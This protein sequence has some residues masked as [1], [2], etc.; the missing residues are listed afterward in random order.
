MTNIGQ[1][2]GK[3]AIGGLI[4]FASSDGNESYISISTSKSVITGTSY[5]GCIAGY[6]SNVSVNN[7]SNEGSE[8]ITVDASIDTNGNKISYVGGYV[9]RG[10]Y[11]S[12]CD[13]NVEIYAV[14]SYVGG[15]AGWSN[16]N[17]SNCNNTGKITSQGDYIGGIIGYL[18]NST[19]VES[20][21]N[22]GDI[23]GNNYVGGII[24]NFN[25]NISTNSNYDVYLTSL[26]N[27]GEIIGNDYVGG[28]SG[29]IYANNS[30][31]GN[32]STFKIER[33]TNAGIIVVLLE[34]SMYGGYFGYGYSDGSASY[35]VY[36]SNL[37]EGL[38]N[39]GQ[40]VNITERS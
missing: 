31:S 11:I 7:C 16:G 17:I 5:V 4:G 19:K 21:S 3:E 14:G 6:T 24:G 37:V 38:Q 29:Y 1:I 30:D 28:I 32:W 18:H 13:N 27:S 40:L 33:L 39:Y 35:I 2:T 12:N 23:L 26:T 20:C 9:G 8:I 34:N 36:S 25:H 10:Y 15:I 22:T